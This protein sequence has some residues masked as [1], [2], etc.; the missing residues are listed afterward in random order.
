MTNHISDSQS[1][2]TRLDTQIVI[3]S[4]LPLP[5]VS[6][7]YLPTGKI[8]E[9]A[10]NEILSSSASEIVGWYKYRKN[11][12]IRPTFRDKLIT[13]GLQKY[14]EK[15]HDKRTFV[16]CNLSN[17][18]SP[19]GS[20]HTFTYRFGKMNCID[21]YEY[22]EDVTA[23]L[24]EKFNGYRKGLRHSPHSI[25]NKII[26]ES[27]I[28]NN[29]T[30]D[31]ILSIQ[32]AV[33][34]RLAREAQLAAKNEKTIKELETEIR[35]MSSILSDKLS[36]DLH[37]AYDQIRKETCINR[38]VEM[39]E[40]CIEAIKSPPTITLNSF[41]LKVNN[42]RADGDNVCIID[43]DENERGSSPILMS[44]GPRPVLNYAAA[45]KNK[46][47]ASTSVSIPSCLF[48]VH[49]IVFIDFE[50]LLSISLPDTW[51]KHRLCD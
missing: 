33:N 9:D 19:T 2:N 3:R 49:H 16:T 38:E 34:V 37:T 35:Q 29:N 21:M 20:T 41:N 11:T 36:T 46:D 14:F 26:K 15:H 44:P 39:A 51:T 30:N 5:T 28:Q 24:G 25:F 8:K 47:I 1:D 27:N 6:L 50:L 13:K 12:N 23:N 31:A 7:F 40:A 17:R 32:E 22:I 45:L 4:A 18:S 48:P 42:H 10:L 43:N